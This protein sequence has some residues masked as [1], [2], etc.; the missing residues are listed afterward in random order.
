MLGVAFLLLLG[1]GHDLLVRLFTTR[2]LCG[3]ARGYEWQHLAAWTNL[4]AFYIIG[5]PLAI[6]FGFTL[7]FQTKGLW[8]EQICD[9]LCQNCV[10]FFITMRTNWHEL[11]LT[12]FN[13]DN[14]FVC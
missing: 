8:M 10:L 13:K 9:L 3:V 2:V 1:L 4:V 6:L 14:D 5:L 7:G 11:D 12:M